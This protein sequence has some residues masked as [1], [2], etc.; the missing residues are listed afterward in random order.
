[1]NLMNLEIRSPKP[2][3]VIRRPSQATCQMNGATPSSQT[4]TLDKTTLYADRRYKTVIDSGKAKL[5]KRGKVD[6]GYR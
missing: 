1:M 3:I 4:L 2:Y 5:P 6:T